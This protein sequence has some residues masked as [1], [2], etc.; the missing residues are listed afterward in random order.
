MATGPRTKRTKAAAPA[1]P[2]LPFQEDAPPAT[3]A[4]DCSVCGGNCKA[5]QPPVMLPNYRIDSREDLE[6]A[7]RELAQLDA[8]ENAANQELGL[9]AI[10][11]K[12]EMEK[13]LTISRC[14]LSTTIAD[15]RVE[16]KRAAEL[17]CTVNKPAL[18]EGDAKSAQLN[19]GV[20]GWRK[21]PD[22]IE[23]VDP[24]LPKGNP[25]WLKKLK[26]AIV[27]ALR[28][29]KFFVQ[30]PV[31]QVYKVEPAVDVA[32][33]KGLLQKGLVKPAEGRSIGFELKEGADKFFITP[34]PAELASQPS[35]PAA[36]ESVS[37]SES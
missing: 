16:V 32:A 27:K 23:P 2:A 7:L 9:A 37:N 19:H 29:F 35:V 21:S 30:V 24:A 14:G 12:R 3:A 36:G 13:R 26:D 5:P 25:T 20:V 33:L 28:T 8:L 11:L 31:L 18:L 34:N 4:P 6:A 22:T 15:W 1:T 10:K 17:Y